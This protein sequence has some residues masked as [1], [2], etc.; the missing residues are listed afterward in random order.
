MTTT[1]WHRKLQGRRLQGAPQESAQPP[2][3]FFLKQN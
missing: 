2:V 3:G 1:F